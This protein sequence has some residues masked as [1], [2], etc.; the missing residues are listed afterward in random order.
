MQKTLIPKSREAFIPRNLSNLH[1]SLHK[2]P[3]GEKLHETLVG[4]VPLP[5]GKGKGVFL[6]MF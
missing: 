3:G 2:Y 1:K 4:S 5:R 6:D